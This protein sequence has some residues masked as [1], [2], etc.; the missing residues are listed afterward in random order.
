MP[1]SIG[2]RFWE[3]ILQY[4]TEH[5]NSDQKAIKDA[6]NKQLR[7]N[8]LAANNPGSI[9]LP[10]QEHSGIINNKLEK[11]PLG[12]PI[13]PLRNNIRNISGGFCSPEFDFPKLGAKEG[14]N[15]ADDII[16]DKND[17]IIT[18]DFENVVDNVPQLQNE[19][20]EHFTNKEN[21][22]DGGMNTTII[23]IGIFVLLLICIILYIYLSRNNKLS[24]NIY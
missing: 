9:L 18:E 15:P 12:G 7:L 4:S 8:D 22:E 23:L 6:Y 13:N 10:S 16:V 1:H 24:R 11:E 20:I 2:Q 3:D 17:S 19:L 21:F 14:K 5:T